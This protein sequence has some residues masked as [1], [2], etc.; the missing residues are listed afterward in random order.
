MAAIA[1]IALAD[2]MFPPVGPTHDWFALC[3]VTG[4]RVVDDLSNGFWCV[5]NCQ[6]R[7]DVTYGLCND[8]VY[9]K[10][11]EIAWNHAQIND[12]SQDDMDIPRGPVVMG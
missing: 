5:V 8:G 7:I 2:A 9:D 6:P 1:R 11:G 3:C 4:Q 10:C 12:V